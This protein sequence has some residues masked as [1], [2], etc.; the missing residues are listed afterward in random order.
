M[1][2]IIF[3][4]HCIHDELQS[5]QKL[6]KPKFLSNELKFLKLENKEPIR[7]VFNFSNIINQTDLYLCNH[8]GQII[9]WNYNRN[10]CEN[11]DLINSQI[12]NKLMDSFEKVKIFLLKLIKV[13]PYPF[14]INITT[15]EE[16]NIENFTVQT[17]LYI[18]VKARPYGKKS[19]TLASAQFDQ[20]S[21]IDNRPI[22]GFIYVNLQRLSLI[23]D[24]EI[25]STIFHEICHILGISSYL[26]KKW[27]NPETGNSYEDSLPLY[28]FKL[29]D[30]FYSKEIYSLSTPHSHNYTIE[31]FNVT[32]FK[33]DVPNEIVLVDRN[34]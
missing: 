27:I 30:D 28:R 10:E 5:K 7:I 2:I 4:H 23:T 34:K 9:Y 1:L 11:E 21:P 29:Q 26:Y 32:H 25:F 17:D 18:T 14:P 16:K 31:R 24:E 15:I 6:V 3:I 12:L 33:N 8:S 22:S 13:N 20:L 19:V